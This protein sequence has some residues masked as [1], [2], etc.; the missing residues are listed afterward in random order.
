MISLPHGDDDSYI[1]EESHDT[2]A[3]AGMYAPSTPAP[4][5]PAAAAPTAEELLASGG[6]YNSVFKSRPRVALSPTFGSGDADGDE[7]MVDENEVMEFIRS[8]LRGKRR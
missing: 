1:E 4:T 7:E 6:D 8:P 5:T 2:T 3:F